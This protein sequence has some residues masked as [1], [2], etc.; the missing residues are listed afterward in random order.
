[1]AL[2][3]RRAEPADKHAAGAG[4][5]HGV[6]TV[7]GVGQGYVQDVHIFPLQT[8]AQVVVVV[9]HGVELLGDELGFGAVPGNHRDQA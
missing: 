2:R 4:G 6:F 7:Q 8:L 1:M 5:F 3:A 9:G